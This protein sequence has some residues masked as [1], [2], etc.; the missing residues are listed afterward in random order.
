MHTFGLAGR[1]DEL[2]EICDL[3]NIILIEDA[4]ESLG[5]F[6]G[7]THTG[8]IADIGIM[9]FNGNKIIT[10]GGG[11]MIL[12]QKKDLGEKFR[13]ITT[14]AKV[15][16]EWHFDHDEIGFNYRMPNLNAALGVAQMK[17]LNTFLETKRNIA[18]SYQKWGKDNSIEFI[19]EI[20]GTT[21]N[22]W[23]N[24]L[25]AENIKERDDILEITNKN[26]VM[27]RPA[28]KPMHQLKINQKFETFEPLMNT[29]WLF[30]RIVC[31]PSSFSKDP[32]LS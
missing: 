2:K 27:T 30:E 13:H 23:L 22:Y 20:Q 18:S 3:H 9:S 4:A 31:M 6:I 12:T 10:T 15:N 24:A 14:T 25:L 19:T 26:G 17:K 8:T 5:T 11:G 7:K 28:W 29:E 16:H 1:V 32:D 21:S